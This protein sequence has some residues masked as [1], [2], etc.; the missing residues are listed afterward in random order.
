M[1]LEGILM[2][3]DYPIFE[4]VLFLMKIPNC[5]ISLILAIKIKRLSSYVLNYLYYIA[6]IGWSVFIGTDGLLFIIAAQSPVFFAI[7]NVLRDVGA[8]MIALI[9]LC[10]VIAGD[11]INEG[12]E[13]ALHVKRRRLLFA[14][15]INF[16]LVVAALLTDSIKVYDISQPAPWPVIDPASLPPT[17]EFIVNFDTQSTEGMIGSALIIVFVGWYAY[18]VI[19]M[20]VVQRN[21]AGVRR[22][23]ARC[24]MAG[25][26][27]IP[28]GIVYFIALG[29]YQTDA[30]WDRLL[31][32]MLGHVIWMLSPVLVYF[33][34]R[35]RV[36][37]EAGSMDTRR[38]AIGAQKSQTT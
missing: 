3:F 21:L 12:E 37:A 18:S 15:I 5:V 34:M 2:A 24:I 28:A 20:F 9:P 10:F 7:A 38:E 36:S 19:Q 22:E 17:G 29:Y 26:L 35:L 30:T 31:L 4:F 33:G 23:R 11:I 27:M 14:V 16:A 6:F 13:V 25:V 8:I 1:R 32:V